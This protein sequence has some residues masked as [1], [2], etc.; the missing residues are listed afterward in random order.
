MK[1]PSLEIGTVYGQWTVLSFVKAMS[2]TDR[3]TGY[4]C[5]CTCG[6]IRKVQGSLLKTGRSKS[7]GCTTQQRLVASGTKPIYQAIIY[8]IYRN[9]D[10]QARERN[11]TFSLSLEEFSKLIT[12]NCHY[13]NDTPSN[14]FKSGAKRYHGLES[15]RY[16]GVDRLD[17]SKGYTLEN[18]VPCCKKCNFAKGK[19]SYTEWLL[20]VQRV[21]HNLNSLGKFN[22]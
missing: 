15:F 5:Q 3:H 2:Q 20:W 18:C 16:N 8:S 22:D 12:Q 7:C 9:Y 10:T 19:F 1:N 14:T 13:C 17:N 4:M 6:T 11:Y 21:Y